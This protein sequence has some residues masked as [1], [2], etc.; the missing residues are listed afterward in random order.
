MKDHDPQMPIPVTEEM[1]LER[2]WFEEAKKQTLDTLPTF[3]DHVMNDYAHSYGTVCHAVSACALA[4]AWAANRAKGACGGITGFQA[5]F[6]MWDF[7]KQ[8]NYPSNEC[9]LKIVDFDNMLYPQYND[10]FQRI[11]SKSTWEALQTAARKHLESAK[12][13]GTH[14]DVLAHWESIVSGNIPF[15]YTVEKSDNGKE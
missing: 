3:V 14:P 12:P 11:L 1:H 10:N 15:G 6:V 9:G 2:E 13:L 7:I 8:W 4:A 5:G